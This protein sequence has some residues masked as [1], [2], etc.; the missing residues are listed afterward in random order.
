M[1]G[2]DFAANDTIYVKATRVNV[3]KGTISIDLP[4]RPPE[5]KGDWILGYKINGTRKYIEVWDIV[6]L[7]SRANP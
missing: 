5:I 1:R 7:K 6:Q 4:V 2:K 3:D